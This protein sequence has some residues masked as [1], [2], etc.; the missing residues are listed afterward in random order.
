VKRGGEGK[1]GDKSWGIR[2]REGGRGEW[3]Y[4]VRTVTKKTSPY[5]LTKKRKGIELLESRREKRESIRKRVLWGGGINQEKGRVSEGPGKEK[6]R[7]L[8]G[9]R[10]V[11]VR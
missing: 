3:K 9:N 10:G 4:E 5:N 2:L 11:Q 8:K 7:K 1:G 6:K